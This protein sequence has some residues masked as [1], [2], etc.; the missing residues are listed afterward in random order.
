MH[1]HHLKK[2]LSNGKI[3]KRPIDIDKTGVWIPWFSCFFFA[4]ILTKTIAI[5]AAITELT[6]I[7]KLFQ[8]KAGTKKPFIVKKKTPNIGSAFS[9]KGNALKAA[10]YQKN[11]CSSKGIFL[12]N[13]T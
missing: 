2:K 4:Y 11:I 12:K 8:T 1:L 6:K 13:S 9:G 3:I 7:S 5:I 10:K